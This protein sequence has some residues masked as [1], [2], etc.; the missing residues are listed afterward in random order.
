MK[1]PYSFADS[2]LL[3]R[4]LSHASA[5]G[6]NNQRLEF[7]GDSVLQLV[8]SE[9]LMERCVDWPEGQLSRARSRLV[10]AGTL[11]GF[12]DQWGLAEVLRVGKGE[13]RA[14]VAA[15]VNIRA[16]AFEAVVAAVYL[17]GGLPAARGALIPL[18]EAAL[19]AL[20]TLVDP[21]SRL[22]EWS[23]ARGLPEPV[24]T[25]LS[26]AGPAHATVFSM[27][28][29][30]DSQTFGPASGESKRRA[31]AAA[32]RLAVEAMGLA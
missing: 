19:D 7:L 14:K 12:A 2:A 8:A 17:D 13:R 31:S 21:R 29:M 15:N 22:L 32:A 25:L 6:E 30:V 23:Q 1:I 16:D 3:E 26:T 20:P 18:L 4:A 27:N 5:G 10:N 24:Y 11:A 9:W 28:V